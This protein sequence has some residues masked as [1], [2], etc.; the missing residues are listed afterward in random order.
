MDHETD[1][2]YFLTVEISD[3]NLTA[4]VNVTIDVLDADEEPT[5][6]NLPA[7]VDVP[8]NSPGGMSVYSVNATDQDVDDV[9]SFS[10]K[11]TDPSGAPFTCDPNTG[12]AYSRYNLF[13]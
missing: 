12:S 1:P 6:S 7:Q 5:I 4:I 8:E 10:L 3:G 2:T 13:Y 11:S 9:L